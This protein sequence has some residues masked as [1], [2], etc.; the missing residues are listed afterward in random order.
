[1]SDFHGVK[2]D[3]T[4]NA[5]RYCSVTG[6]WD[7]SNYQNCTHITPVNKTCNELDPFSWDIKCSAY[8]TSIIYYIGYTIS[9]I[10]LILAVIVFLNFKEL[11]CLRNTI[12]INLFLTYILWIFLWILT[13]TLQMFT[14]SSTVGCV[15]SAIFLHYFMLTNFFW[16]MVEGLYLYMLV[17]QTFS[18]DN[19][20]FNLYFIIG[21]CFPSIFVG[22]WTIFKAF[23]TDADNENVRLTEDITTTVSTTETESRLVC[24]WMR[25]SNIDW[26]IQGPACA[27]L[28]IN[29]IFLVRIMWVLIT[30]LRSANTVET[31]QYRKASKALLVLIPLLGI[32]YLIVIAGPNEGF[33]SHIFAILRAF[34]LSIQGLSVSLFY[35]FL[36][37]EVRQALKHRFHRL[38]DSR[39]LSASNSIRS[40]RYTMSKDYSPRSRTESI[41]TTQEYTVI[42]RMTE[43]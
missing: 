33:E 8:A 41:R 19:I 15:L 3:A 29:L 38:R 7:L 35:C 13:L 36:N 43:L 40:R 34:L 16:M 11:R 9:L 4:S 20:R 2:Y 28:I 39:N 42:V 6:L 32:T 12:H 17:V 18:G 30:K 24:S 14:G 26:I 22:F 1:M 25:E 5:T 27:V 23:A 31:R 37:S 10:T 21:W